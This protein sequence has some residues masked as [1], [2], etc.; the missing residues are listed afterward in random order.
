MDVLRIS[1]AMQRKQKLGSMSPSTSM[2]TS[3]VNSSTTASPSSD[4]KL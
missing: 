4:I 2:V 1:L 3:P